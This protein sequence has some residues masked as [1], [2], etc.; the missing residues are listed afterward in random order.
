[1]KAWMLSFAAVVVVVAPATAHADQCEWVDPAVAEKAQ[2]LLESHPKVIAF[3]EPC[4]DKAPGV[5]AVAES[6]ELDE[7]GVRIN[8]S[9]VDL[10]YT[11]VQTSPTQYQNLALLA[12]CE[13]HDVSPSLK[14]AEETSNGVLIV[15][16]DAPVAPM[17]PAPV[18]APQAVPPHVFVF[19][20]HTREPLP[21]LTIV[22][23]GIASF[24]M[25]LAGILAFARLRRRRA[26]KPRAEQLRA[27]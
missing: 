11:F 15:P 1:M 10:A 22:L 25:S 12:G 6:V 3:C 5:P 24:T 7:H 13:A 17:L 21:W 26:M 2:Q 18:P 27:S 4:G 16:D 9:A 23:A 14:V 8:G 20:T 19:S